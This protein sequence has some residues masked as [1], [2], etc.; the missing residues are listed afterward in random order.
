MLLKVFILWLGVHLFIAGH[1]LIVDREPLQPY[2]KTV[3][4]Y[5]SDVRVREY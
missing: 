5:Y 2:P 4:D 1:Y 3:T